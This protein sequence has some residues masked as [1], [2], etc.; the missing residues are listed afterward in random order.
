MVMDCEGQEQWV[1]IFANSNKNL[2][3]LLIIIQT[4]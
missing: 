4:Q 2:A 3:T 1:T